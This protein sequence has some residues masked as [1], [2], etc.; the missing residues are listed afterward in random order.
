MYRLKSA[1]TAARTVNPTPV[2]SPH[3]ANAYGSDSTPPPITVATRLNEELRRV[4]R[5]EEEPAGGW[6]FS[7]E[8][9]R[10]RRGLKLNVFSDI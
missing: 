1:I 2:A 5:R 3:V 7:K 9:A 6:M 10:R 8:G 4:L